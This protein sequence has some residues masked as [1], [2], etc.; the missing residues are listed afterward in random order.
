MTVGTFEVAK[1]KPTFFTDFPTST[2]SRNRGYMWIDGKR[3]K[4][5]PEDRGG[6]HE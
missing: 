2:P 3:I 6:E 4:L 5:P 1:R